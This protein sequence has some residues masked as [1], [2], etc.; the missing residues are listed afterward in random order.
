MN[1]STAIA[2]LVAAPLA[3]HAQQGVNPIHPMFAPLDAEGRK[4][5]WG[6]DVSVDKTCGACHDAQ[7]VS[8]HSGHATGKAKATCVECHLD[9]GR[10][11]VR[12]EML[13][14]EGRLRR[15]FIRIGSP[16]AANCA[17]CHGMVSDGTRP[18]VVPEDFEKVPRPEGRTWRLT[19]GEGAV[20]APQRMG[21]SFLNLEGKTSLASPWDVHAAKL[22][23]CVACHYATNNPMRTDE[24]HAKLRYLTAD[25]RRQSTA[26]FLVRPD[27]RLAAEECR[28]CHDPFKAHVFLPYRERHMAVLACATCHIAGPMAP[29]VEMVDATVVTTTGLP[30]VRYRNLTRAPGEP[31]NT[32]TVRPLRPLLV[33]REEADGVRRLAPVNPVSR[34]R[35]ISGL[36]RVEVP[37]D[38]VAQAFLDGQGY[39]A[40]VLQAFDANRDGRIDEQELRLDSAAKV[41]LVARRLRALGVSEPTI[42]GTLE[43]Y[44]LSHGVPARERALRDCTA[45]HAGSSRVAEDFLIA[46]Y[47][48][49]GTPPRPREGSKVELAGLLAIQSDGSLML[50][51]DQ[52]SAPTDLHVLGHSRQGFTNTL[53]FA[54]FVAVALGVSAH[55]IMRVV[56]RKMRSGADTHATGGSKG[57]EYVFGSYERIWHWT[58]AF[59]GMVLIVTGIVIHKSGDR[60]IIDLPKAVSL[61]N[62]FAVVLM[63]NAFLA[64]FYHLTTKAIRNFIPE[65]KGFLGRVLSHMEYQTRGIFFGG[66]HPVNAP[67]HK[68]NPLQQ[69]TYLGLLNFLF[70]LQ[71]VTGVLIWTVGNWPSAAT[72]LGGLHYLA[73][74]HNLGSWLFLS[75][76]VLHVYLVTTGRTPTEH[77]ESML[78]GYQPLDAEEP[79]P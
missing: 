70:P 40:Q 55:G 31:L 20:V 77:L 17:T 21:D 50:H 13:D 47:L 18:V 26:E 15:E 34:F 69:V 39:A 30:L 16:R 41:D 1:R 54:L 23:D 61:H 36:D 5:R 25:P 19:Q 71:I 58:M 38:L 43:V 28:R 53:G 66:P 37:G 29:A 44:P 35:W 68:L 10:L 74:I 64:L 8:A 11:E 27:H 72:A 7:Y 79:T 46:G 78:T 33:E 75:F 56:L 51:R 49:G 52:D 6:G 62:V 2:L 57:K 48:P 65:P 67:G 12:P 60:A 59:S 45:C 32:A 22:V 4:V 73:P 63:A 9:M 14:A 3:A 42:E 76:F 24:K